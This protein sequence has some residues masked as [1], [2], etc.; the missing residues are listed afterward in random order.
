[1][2]NQEKL[3]ILKCFHKSYME[4]EKS[5]NSNVFLVSKIVMTKNPYFH[6]TY[7]AGRKYRIQI[8]NLGYE[9]QTLI[10]H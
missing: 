5:E 2:K 3:N 1:M 8:D 4:S 10:S 9:K 6:I 7:R